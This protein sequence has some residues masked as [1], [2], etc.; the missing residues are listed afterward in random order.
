VKGLE[1]LEGREGEVIGQGRNS[2]SSRNSKR[3]EMVSNAFGGN[4][5]FKGWCAMAKANVV[6]AIGIAT[7]VAM[8]AEAPTAQNP[9]F[10]VASIK[11][12]KSGGSFSTLGFSAGGRFI[13]NNVSVR[14]LIMA[15][16]GTPEPLDA[17][18]VVGGSGWTES[19]RFDVVAKA[20]GEFPPQQI[21][22]M[23][24]SLLAE[25]FELAVHNESRE[26]PIYALVLAR[27][28]GTLGPQLRRSDDCTAPGRGR[29]T[30]PLPPNAPLCGGR[31]SPGRLVFGGV[32]LSS[33]IGA[34][35]LT[36]ELKRI[37]VDRTGLTGAF[38]GTLEWTP[39]DM[40]LPPPGPAPPDAP[41]P[42]RADGPSIFTAVQ[43]QLGLKLESTKGPADV[44]VIDRVEHPAED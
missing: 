20:A 44:L 15:A 33:V 40:P 8:L 7:V 39:V 29:A 3:R 1:G 11:P 9:A 21:L 18:R 5:R 27:S 28:D 35:A 22:L 37:V 38:D 42:P 13:A 26:V 24:R 25:R 10:E 41:P 32:P 19:D 12:N 43:E 6:R 34:P 23:L 16:Y 31:G 30:A 4:H 2:Q 36:R 14:Q 17:S